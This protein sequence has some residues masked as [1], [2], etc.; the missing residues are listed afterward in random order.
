MR[1]K[2]H[3]PVPDGYNVENP[4]NPLTNISSSDFEK[5]EELAY[6]YGVDG[7]SYSKLSD[8]FKKEWDIDFDNV[9]TLIYV[10]SDDILKMDPSKEKAVLLDDEFQEIGVGIY[11][12]ADFLRNLGFRADLIHP[13]DDRVS[14]RAIA[15]Q[16]NDC[17]IIRSNMCL[18]KEGLA[19]G[20]FQISTSIENLP[21][22]DKNDMLWVSDYCKDCGNCIR[23]CPHD[24]YDEDEKV[25]KKACL[26][27]HEG[28]SEC[29]LK[30]PFYKKGYDKVK[31][32][33]E[34]NK[35]R[36]RV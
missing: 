5:F 19:T 8:D 3:K 28:C 4:S 2:Y 25:I 6:S 13:L 16:S 7:I 35:K 17:A 36:M 10:I 18:F 24:A 29:M 20:F 34:K 30:C 23:N 26:A 14:L 12:L 11:Q 1:F 27:H 15:R 9:I 32:L 33:Y 22:K 31:I 21:F